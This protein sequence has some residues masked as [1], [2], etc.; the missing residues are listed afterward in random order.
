MCAFGMIINSVPATARRTG[1][2]PDLTVRPRGRRKALVR[3]DAF[4]V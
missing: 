2:C 1:W 3:Q 4:R